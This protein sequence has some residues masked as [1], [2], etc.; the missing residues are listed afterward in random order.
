MILRKNEI[1][2]RIYGEV[3]TNNIKGLP[4]LD[5]FNDLINFGI[6]LPNLSVP[7][8]RIFFPSGFINNLKVNAMEFISRTIK[9]DFEKLIVTLP[10]YLLWLDK[11]FIGNIKNYDNIL[12]KEIVEFIVEK[13]KDIKQDFDKY[14][15]KMSFANIKNVQSI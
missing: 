6:S 13:K 14:D 5:Y 3:L 4:K 1:S 15:W 12:P 8:P 10:E 7:I 9:I 2:K 11:D